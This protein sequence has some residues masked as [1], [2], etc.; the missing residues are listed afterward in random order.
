MLPA[1]QIRSF[2]IPDAIWY[3]GESRLDTLP[4]LA[5]PARDALAIERRAIKNVN[6]LQEKRRYTLCCE[7][8]QGI[9]EELAYL[10]DVLPQPI[11]WLARKNGMSDTLSAT[12]Y[13]ACM[14]VIGQY[15]A[16]IAPSM[17]AQEKRDYLYERMPA[18]FFPPDHADR[19]DKCYK[20]VCARADLPALFSRAI[21]MFPQEAVGIS[22]EDCRQAFIAR[23]ELVR[24]SA[25]KGYGLVDVVELT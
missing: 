11:I 9:V 14:T 13:I 7:R 17:S 15:L 4:Q 21:T 16:R 18:V 25:E 19:H 22:I 23:A 24:I 6:I 12:A 20:Y 1:T 8:M 3:K 2:A 5:V 10:G